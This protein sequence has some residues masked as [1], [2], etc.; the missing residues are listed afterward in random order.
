MYGQ[1]QPY[2]QPYGVPTGPQP[3]AQPPGVPVAQP[4]YGQ[5]YAPGAHTTVVVQ[6]GF[7]AG[8]RF[9]GASR[10][11]IP[12]PPPGCAPNAAQLAAAQ[13]CQLVVTQRPNDLFMGGSDGG[14]SMF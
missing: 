6:G 13:G 12:P 2:A 8:A 3:Y 1:P 11:N 14:Y 4:Y 10:P 7:D 5:Q 9:D